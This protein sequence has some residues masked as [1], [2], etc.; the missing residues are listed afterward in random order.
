MSHE[1]GVSEAQS[2]KTCLIS[3]FMREKSCTSR[4]EQMLISMKLLLARKGNLCLRHEF[5][6]RRGMRSSMSCMRL[7]L[8]VRIRLFY[9]GFHTNVRVCR[10]GYTAAGAVTLLVVSC[11]PTMTLEPRPSHTASNRQYPPL[12]KSNSAMTASW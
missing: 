6:T 10:P 7:T 8:T 5:C 9:G 3:N 12:Q 11:R 1:C 2:G 4:R